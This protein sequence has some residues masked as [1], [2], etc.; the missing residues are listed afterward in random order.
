MA[1]LHL[2]F[3]SPGQEWDAIVERIA[4]G[5]SVLLLADGVLGVRREAE[6]LLARGVR[7]NVLEADL[8]AR[9]FGSDHPMIRVIDFDGFVDLTVAHRRILSW[10]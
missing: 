5:D 3:C 7:L 4:P 9:G 1:V 2:I 10:K 8:R 6:R